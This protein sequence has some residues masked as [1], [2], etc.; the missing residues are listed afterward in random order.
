MENIIKMVFDYGV[1]FIL[2]ALVI[3]VLIMLIKNA[4]GAFKA[5]MDI[6]T[7]SND[8]AKDA[9]QA[10]DRGNKIIEEYQIDA[11]AYKEQIESLDVSVK[12]LEEKLE[13]RC[14]GIDEDNL[15]LIKLVSGISKSIEALK[16]S[17]NQEREWLNE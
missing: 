17:P 11:N 12:K 13:K 8:I 9:T 1:S 7:N 15:E 6:L 16:K 10:I 3:V 5:F 4:P 2:S 14:D